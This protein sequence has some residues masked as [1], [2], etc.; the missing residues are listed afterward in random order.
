MAIEAPKKRNPLEGCLVGSLLYTGASALTVLA[1]GAADYALLH[2]QPALYNAPQPFRLGADAL[3]FVA[4][5][6]LSFGTARMA[7]RRR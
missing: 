2:L 7:M 5:A 4:T 3:A 6:A 1:T